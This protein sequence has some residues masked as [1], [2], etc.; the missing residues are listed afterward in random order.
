MVTPKTL[1][2]SRVRRGGRG[3]LQGARRRVRASRSA[4]GSPTCSCGCRRSAA[5][6]RRTR[7]R[8]RSRTS[9]KRAKGGEDFAKL[10]REISEDTASAVQGGDLGFVGP[11]ELVPQFEQ[12]AF[13]LKKGEI[14]RRRSAPRS[15]IT[16][17]RCS[18][19]KEGGKTAASRKSPPKIKE[20]L[21]RRAERAGRADQGGRGAGHAARGQGLPG[22]GQAARARG[23][24]RRPSGAAT[25]S[26]RRAV[27]RSSTR[28]LFG[29]AV[30]GVSTPIKTAGGFAIVKIVQQRPG[31]GAAGGRDPGP[32]RRGHQA[33]AGRAAGDRQGARPS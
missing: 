6:R 7:P 15:A 16:P 14:S 30:G 4:C 9:I 20:K 13:A 22:R 17:S 29:L 10:A 3:L 31:R 32:R 19:C 11:G 21:A 2:L 5:A 27:I 24:R 23:R 26:A 8:R 33:R 28:R 25:P 18:T 12:A 1:T